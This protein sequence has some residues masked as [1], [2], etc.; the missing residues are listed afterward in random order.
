MP[1][2]NPRYEK[3]PRKESIDKF[4]EGMKRHDCV[5]EVE[6]VSDIYY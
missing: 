6:K 3:I 5:S 4:V 1:D 2:S